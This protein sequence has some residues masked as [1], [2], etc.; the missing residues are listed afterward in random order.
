[1]NIFNKI[2]S[3]L[4]KGKVFNLKVGDLYDHEGV[5]GV[6]ISLDASGNHGLV[7]SLGRKHCQWYD[8]DYD[9]NT[10]SR[11]AFDG[12]QNQDYV[13]SNYGS[14]HYPAFRWCASLGN[15]WY[16]PA[17][18][19]LQPLCELSNFRA[20][21]N[22]L[23][24]CGDPLFSGENYSDLYLSSTE[25]DCNGVSYDTDHTMVQVFCATERGGSISSDTKRSDYEF[26]RAVHRF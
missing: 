15:G 18:G 10:H 1:M 2:R 9:V 16:L 13:L 5:K 14:S 7:M 20:V 26:A 22:T 24:T 25:G 12:K 21:E 23:A 3:L 6:I 19:E 4:I 17:I 11:H 8:G